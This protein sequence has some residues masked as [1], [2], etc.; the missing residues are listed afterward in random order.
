MDSHGSNSEKWGFN[1]GTVMTHHHLEIFG[2]GGGAHRT[3][4]L[5]DAHQSYS[6]EQ[7]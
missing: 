4:F 2:W 5:V 7:S 3:V 1:S 6:V